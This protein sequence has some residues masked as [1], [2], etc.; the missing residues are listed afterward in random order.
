MSYRIQLL[1]QE[2][3]PWE[4]EVHGLRL[5]TCSRAIYGRVIVPRCLLRRF[6]AA[7]HAPTM[8]ERL[9]YIDILIE[10][11]AAERWPAVAWPNR[12]AAGYYRPEQVQ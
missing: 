1:R 9:I 4:S 10:R 12:A 7:T 8:S 2:C 6:L 5:L 11:S 3:Q